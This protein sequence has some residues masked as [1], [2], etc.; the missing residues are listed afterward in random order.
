MLVQGFHKSFTELFGLVKRQSKDRIIAGLDSLLWN[1]KPISEEHE[2][3]NQ[4]RTHL[5]DA[6]KALLKGNHL[7]HNYVQCIFNH[8]F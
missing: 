2:K 3:L 7:M 1:K 5:V 4:L 6:E 8:I